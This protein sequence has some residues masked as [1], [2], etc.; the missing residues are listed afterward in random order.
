MKF[1]ELEGKA[2][3][4]YEDYAALMR[5]SLDCALDSTKDGLRVC[6]SPLEQ[7]F[8]VTF[9]FIA[10]PTDN[11]VN[12]DAGTGPEFRFEL[13]NDSFLI[14][15]PQAKIEIEGHTYHADFLL[16]Y[17]TRRPRLASR[18]QVVV[19]ID[20][21]N[22]HERTKEQARRDRTRDRA[23]IRAGF[24]VFRFTGSE[25]H[26]DP[27]RAAQE[28]RRYIMDFERRLMDTEDYI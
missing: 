1:L 23:M 14:I 6:Q 19:E 27:S 4:A 15:E 7:L 17:K 22:F 10:G 21:H 11:V 20:G 9:L 3:E 13:Y 8:L 26:A 16:T 24:V 28:V 2:L 18:L 5:G 25:I 12:N